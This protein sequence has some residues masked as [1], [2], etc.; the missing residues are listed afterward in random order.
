[1][2]LTEAELRALGERFDVE[3]TS[4]ELD[5]IL[6]GI[7][8]YLAD[9]NT[10]KALEISTGADRATGP[11]REWWNQT[12]DPLNA[13][14][15]HCRLSPTEDGCLSGMSVGLKDNVLVRDI[16][17]TV[18]SE[19]FTGFI[20][21]TDATIVRRLL[22]AG[23]TVTA[24]LTC[25]ELAASGS[26]VTAATGPVKNPHDLSRTA[27]GS[28]GG[29]AAAVAAGLVDVAIGTDTGGSIRIPASFCGV[30][31]LKPTYGLV[32]Q[33]GVVENTYTMDHV[34]P[35]T[36]SVV[37]AARVLE[38]IASP[39]AG[40]PAS[41]AAAGDPAYQV[42]DYLDQVVTGTALEDVRLGV[43]E[44]GFGDDVNGGIAATTRTAIANLADAGVSVSSVSIE[45]FTEGS[46]IKNVLSVGELAA[47]WDVAGAPYR[48]R[49]MVDT[50]YQRAFRDR[51]ERR[52]DALGPQYK[53]KLLAG[54]ALLEIDG[55]QAYTAATAARESYRRVFDAALADVDALVLPTMPGVAPRIEAASDP[56]FE[57]GRNTR[58]F[59]VTG[60]PAITV[61]TAELDG[62]PVGLQL[63]GEHFQ[64]GN[65]LAIADAVSTA[66]TD[67]SG[68]ARIEE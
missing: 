15:C 61:P 54:A 4:D 40:D 53:R 27:G 67:A 47:H 64:E 33:S 62:L 63:V 7:H 14:A 44:Q 43:L 30:V 50:H 52:E 56:G 38:A 1:M 24:K 51:I 68:D 46:A 65:L 8:S 23:S 48:R 29:S 20:P 58:P 57:R 66:L 9:A 42:G 13:I 26:G 31:G 34:G 36:R 17:M 28:S 37:D 6:N 39:D 32:P 25:D 60:H 19:L 22:R 3:L 18:G 45:R 2:R 5:H 55:G 35:I 11:D 49:G 10:V 59:N 21:R 41:L 12:D 16:P